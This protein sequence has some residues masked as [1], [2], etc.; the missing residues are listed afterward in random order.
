MKDKRPFKKFYCDRRETFKLPDSAFKLWMYLYVCENIDRKAWPSVETIAKDCNLSVR[1]IRRQKKLLLKAGWL[2]NGGVKSFRNNQ[3]SI[4]I[5]TVSRGVVDSEWVTPSTPAKSYRGKNCPFGGDKN[6]RLGVTKTTPKVDYKKKS[7]EEEENMSL[8]NNIIISCRKILKVRLQPNDPAWTDLKV[9]A[10][11]HGPAVVESAFEQWAENLE[12]TPRHP[13]TAFASKA[14]TILE[15]EEREIQT[16]K[17]LIRELAEISGGTIRF[18]KKY[19]AEVSQFLKEFTA[20]EIKS[21]FAQFVPTVRED[22][23]EWAAKDFA[24]TADQLIIPIRRNKK[25]LEAAN[26]EIARIENTPV[27]VPDEPEDFEL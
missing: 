23:L 14:D 17:G 20:D 10:Q 19:A 22:K 15:D 16:D 7:I 1:T 8:K 2:Q 6:D 18:N 27:I 5:Y 9:L 13:L 12:E 4:P 21:A 24:E 3:F 11:I 25:M 26:A